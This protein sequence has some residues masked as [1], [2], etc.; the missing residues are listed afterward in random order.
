MET[1]GS[2]RFILY[3]HEP[4]QQDE[5]LVDAPE[6][7]EVEEMR[8]QND[9]EGLF[10]AMFNSDDPEVKFAIDDALED[11][12]HRTIEPFIEAL[13]NDNPWVRSG[14]AWILWNVQNVLAMGPLLEAL[15]DEDEN[16][17]WLVVAALGNIGDRSAIEPISMVPTGDDTFLKEIVADALES[18]KSRC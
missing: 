9:A 4:A 10:K 1:S 5:D 13:K 6:F 3:R 7:A 14:A 15:A 17:R 11:V 12:G 18:I 8:I 16:V 2:G